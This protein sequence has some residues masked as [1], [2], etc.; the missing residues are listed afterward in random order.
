MIV[1]LVAWVGFGQ[2]P[3]RYD[4]DA[5]FAGT[6]KYPFFKML[7]VSLDAMTA[8][9][10]AP[11]RIVFLV[12]VLAMAIAGVLLVWTFYSFFFLNAVPGWSS[13]MVI[14]LFFT[15]VQLFSLAFVGEYVGR[16]FIETKR[17]PLYV[18]RAIYPPSLDAVDAM[19]QRRV[20]PVTCRAPGQ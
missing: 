18:I 19:G 17:R 3:F 6:T 10:T 1:G 20:E 5:R 16:I 2:V 7:A 11:L 8:F 12:A 9:A 14:Y 13:L 4:R 15:S